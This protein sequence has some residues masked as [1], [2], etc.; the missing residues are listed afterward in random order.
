VYRS[1]VP[2]APELRIVIPLLLIAS[3]KTWL[4]APTSAAVG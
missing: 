1:I 4:P 2:G 3:W